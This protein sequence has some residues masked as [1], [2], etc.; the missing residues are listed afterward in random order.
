[1]KKLTTVM[2]FVSIAIFHLSLR[3][4]F[5]QYPGSNQVPLD[6]NVIPKFV[7]PLP[8]FAGARV[9]VKT[10]GNLIATVA[11]SKQVALSTGTVLDNGIV[12]VKG[13]ELSKTKLWTYSFSK[14]GGKTWTT[15]NWPGYTIDAQKGYPVN[16]TYVNALNGQTYKDLNLTIHTPIPN[17]PPHFGTTIIHWQLHVWGFIRVLQECTSSEAPTK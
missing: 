7:D 11:P 6:P 3:Q 9:D 8:H 2:L 12:V 13:C 1:M 4:G 14:D 15:P 16:V 5:G 17:K 10:G